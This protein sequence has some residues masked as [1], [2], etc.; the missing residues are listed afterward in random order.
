MKHRMFLL[1]SVTTLLHPCSVNYMSK[2]P[3]KN[4]LTIHGYRSGWAL[5]AA[6]G[7]FTATTI[8]GV[9]VNYNLYTE[10][11]NKDLDE[12]KEFFKN[13]RDADHFF[14]TVP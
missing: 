10:E 8:G 11:A 1:F 4:C 3:K 9:T 13:L 14:I 2:R 12:C 6:I 5:S 7:T